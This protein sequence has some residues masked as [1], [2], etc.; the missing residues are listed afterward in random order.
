[1]WAARSGQVFGW[2]LFVIGAYL[3][4][5]RRDYSWLWFIILGWFLTSAA[6][7]ENQQVVV[8]SRL[9]TVAMREIMTA[10]PVTVPETRPEVPGRRLRTV[11]ST[12]CSLAA[13]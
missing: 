6:T 8:Q 13:V 3:V 7:A 5:A 1:M 11:S 2:A 4:L 12:V 9:R 10:N